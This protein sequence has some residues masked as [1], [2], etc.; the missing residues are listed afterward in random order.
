VDNINPNHPL[1]I[2]YIGVPLKRDLYHC[3]EITLFKASPER[4]KLDQM[5]KAANGS[6]KE[7]SDLIMGLSLLEITYDFILRKK[8]VIAKMNQTFKVLI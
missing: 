5:L 3:H 4:E 7:H 8:K 6:L 1:Y 2:T